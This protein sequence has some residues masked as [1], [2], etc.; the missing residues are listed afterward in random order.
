MLKTLAGCAVGAASRFVRVGQLCLDG[1]PWGQTIS[2]KKE[3]RGPGFDRP[4]YPPVSKLVAIDTFTGERSKSLP[5]YLYLFSCSE[6]ALDIHLPLFF[7]S[8]CEKRR[9]LLTVSVMLVYRSKCHFWNA[10]VFVSGYF[11]DCIHCSENYVSG[12]NRDPTC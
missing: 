5:L 8:F 2:S 12:G 1:Q 11:L 7:S 4:T 9:S 6:V 3:T 10:F